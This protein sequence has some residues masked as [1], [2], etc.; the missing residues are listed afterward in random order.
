VPTVADGPVVSTTEGK[1]QGTYDGTAIVFRGVPFAAPPVGPLRFKPPQRPDR[2]EGVRPAVEFGGACPQPRAGVEGKYGVMQAL[3]EDCLYLNLWTPATDDARRPVMVFL[4]G[5][6][7]MIGA[8]SSK[9]YNGTRT[10]MRGAVVVTVNY[11]LG[12]FGFLHLADLMPGYEGSGNAALL[13]AVRAVEW[14]KENIEAF[15]GD[16]DRITLMGSSAGGCNTTSVIAMPASA[17]LIRRAVPMSSVSGAFRTRESG[18]EDTLAVYSTLGLD[19][20]QPESILTVPSMRFVD[21]VGRQVMQPIATV[22]GDTLP[23][24][25]YLAIQGGAA[26]ELD[27]IVGGTTEERRVELIDIGESLE[28]LNMDRPNA[29]FK[30]G[31]YSDLST[32]VPWTGMSDAQVRPVFEA[33]VIA[34]GRAGSEIDIWASALSQRMIQGGIKLADSRV[35]AQGATFVYS[36]AWRSPAQDEKFGAYHGVPTPFI[37]DNADLPSWTGTLGDPPPLELSRLY[38]ES[39]IA[40]AATGSP[41]VEGLPEWRA[42]EPEHRWTMRWD[43]TPEVV[44][45]P[46]SEVRK[47]WESAPESYW[48]HMHG[49][50][51]PI[52]TQFPPPGDDR[53]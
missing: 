24:P 50:G 4:H 27:V 33:A 7:N 41:S 16:P 23:M 30:V 32:F 38:N 5:G 25:A 36:M 52:G 35:N 47:L 21:L 39:L 51:E 28:G 15:G 53:R 42:Y 49:S 3:D 2:W 20:R 45:D 43:R 22:D 44:S 29:Q 19:P 48:G 17:G 18:H 6:A 1:L 31:D 14:V 46:D 11:R 9:V 37:F 10:A 34:G 40:F 13:D 12:A 8:G 26:S